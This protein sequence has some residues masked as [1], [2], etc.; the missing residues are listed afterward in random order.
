M[1]PSGNARKKNIFRLF[2]VPL[3]L[4]MLVQALLC[5]GTV[6]G[7]GTF[8]TLSSNS[9]NQ[10]GQAVENRRI[11]LENNMVQRWSS[12][13]EAAQTAQQ[14]L[15]QT[16]QTRNLS[17]DDF[18]SDSALQEAYL[19]ALLPD[20]VY[21]MRRN[22][23]T[24]S[25]LILNAPGLVQSGGEAN[26]IYLRDTDPNANPS[27]YSDL[28]LALGAPQ[29]AQRYHVSLSS[30]WKP[31]I[32]LHSA[33]QQCPSEAFF[34]NP[35][36]AA[37][38]NPKIGAEN[39][40]YW[41]PLFTLGEDTPDSYQMITCSMPLMDADGTVFG[42]MGI[43]LSESYL[44]DVLPY[45]EVDSTGEGG[46]L[47]LMENADG[48]YLPV[49]SSGPAAKRALSGQT[50][51]SLTETEYEDLY[52]LQDSN[53]ANPFY[54]SL[55]PLR[56]YN[57]NTPFAGRGWYLAGVED[58]SMLFGIVGRL[59]HSFALAIC[60]AMLFG[61]AGI[62]ISVRHVTGP[63]R[64]LSDCI[65][66]S[67][68]DRLAAFQ[69][70]GVSEVDELYSTIHRLTEQQKQAEQA[71]REETERYR[72][73]LRSSSD[74][75]LTYDFTGDRAEFFN[76]S[77][78]RDGYSIDRFRSM[79]KEQALIPEDDLR[80]LT[81]RLK[82][83]HD[84][85]SVTFRSRLFQADGQLRWM[86]LSGRILRD[87]NGAS[88]K[89]F[90]TLR[91]IH[92]EKLRQLRESESLH[93]DPITGL[94]NRESGEAIIQA[95]VEGGH[96]GALVVLDIRDF[97]ALNETYGMVIGD[98]VLESFGRLLLRAKQDMISRGHDM[99]AVRLG[100]D[101]FL[102]WLSGFDRKRAQHFCDALS[103]QTASLFPGLQF[104][105]QLS[106]GAALSL[107]GVSYAALR[108]QTIDAL[109]AAKSQPTASIIFADTLTAAARAAL[110]DERSPS[111]IARLVHERP[112]MTTLTFNFFDKSHDVDSILAVLLPK[113]GTYYEASDVTLLQFDWNF[114][115]TQL[116]FQWHAAH[117]DAPLPTVTRRHPTDALQQLTRFFSNEGRD[118]L[119]TRI[120]PANA[121]DWLRLPAHRDGLAFPLYDNGTLMS[122]LFFLRTADAPVWENEARDELL[123]VVRII[124][125]NL[126]RARYDLASRAKSDFLSRMSHEIRTPMNAIIGMTMIAQQ[127]KEDP[128]AISDALSKIDQSS[129]YLLSLINDILDMSKIESGK[130]SIE[131]T[132]FD[133]GALLNGL[134]TLFRPQMDA[135]QLHFR[136]E[137]T[138]GPRWVRGDPLHLNQ[139]LVNLL[140]NALKFT[141]ADGT[142]TLTA[143][144]EADG[145][146]VAFSVRD[147][148]IGISEE[149]A[150]RI[151]RSFE[152]ADD[153]TARQYGGTG[154]GLAISSRLVSMMGGVIGLDSTPG[155]GSDFH[156]SISLPVAE[157][158]LV[159]Q[160]TDSADDAARFAGRRLLLV[161]DND[162]NTEIAQALLEM[163]G[164]VVEIARNGQE[165]VD[166]F[167]SSA[168]GYYDLILMDI[169]MPVMDGLTATR[170][171][172]MLDRPDAGIIP[173]VA[174]TANAF[175]E[176]TRKSVE[177]GMNGHL[178]KPID[179]KKLTDTLRTLL[180]PRP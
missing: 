83:A 178:S 72:L 5:Y 152:Q 171:I 50:A 130:M 131:R 117:T 74:I 101:E 16:L 57:Y 79:L 139:V 17:L 14:T 179:L 102:V 34:F 35:L 96:A 175:D 106:A 3:V 107:G 161:E 7:S 77:G 111:Q 59:T 21:L 18:L 75:L 39:L 2:L 55:H 137:H 85:F 78:Q 67:T 8:A 95:S 123:E 73:A 143:Q 100:G 140:S 169:R 91:N 109:V 105:L 138:I 132:D 88:P 56:L 65:A 29:S 156:F 12:F 115:T 15:T 45:Q 66:D 40:I 159:L 80:V 42:I 150:A 158:R 133:L 104:P 112:N 48:T 172:R 103:A 135:K 54:L 49:L 97:L 173:I 120:L 174:M 53:E 94:Y 38:E 164:F 119:L 63:I 170:H 127:H 82:D 9:A 148:G 93:R 92:E 142:V 20:W 23:V 177:S 160:N 22:M 113:L 145:A 1:K 166:S 37:Q 52:K 76:L 108:A 162:L 98:T 136:I 151:F 81:A 13:S 99:V 146:A 86:E 71:L 90:G 51:L 84:D 149:N 28:L 154:L 70:T 24:G 60:A 124:E 144:R 19:D 4:I 44:R 41:N 36:L 168:P 26:A 125:S 126:N 121:R 134:D 163:K 165:A 32:S 167:R 58:D 157:Q 153:A 25:F 87:K 33:E 147:T 110:P 47:L 10:F 69:L 180:P 114:Y 116:S 11:T 61:I 30:F 141:P 89:L 122:I 43:E 6:L 64:R 176:D 46:Y 62:Y 118:G 27:D 68:A 31:K 155:Q 128:A 129:Q